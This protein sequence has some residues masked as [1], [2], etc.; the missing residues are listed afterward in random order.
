M[1]E[2]YGI[3]PALLAFLK[4]EEGWRAAPYLCQAGKPTI[5]Y[6][7]RIPSLD[8]PRITPEEGE[9]LLADDLRQYRQ[10]AL[11]LSPVLAHEPEARLAAVIDFCYNAG[12]AAYAA[13]T[14]RKRVNDKQWPEAAAEM[15]R[16]VY[17]TDPTTKRKVKL[18]ALVKRRAITAGW[19]EKGA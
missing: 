8:H 7:H 15:R 16:W 5:G 18:A 14:C 9:R 4:H 12:V 13:S 11:E 10:R 2:T 3:T 6:G 1:S 17:I 19:L